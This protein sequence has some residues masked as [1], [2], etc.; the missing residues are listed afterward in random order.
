MHS[1]RHCQCPQERGAE[2]LSK[3][4]ER[5]SQQFGGKMPL[6][7]PGVSVAAV[8]GP[9]I[10]NIKQIIAVW[11]RGTG[12][13]AVRDWLVDSWLKKFYFGWGGKLVPWDEKVRSDYLI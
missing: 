2:Q 4:K 10:C 6:L 11:E 9:S 13:P 5:V 8:A 1:P 12:G 7:R 3:K